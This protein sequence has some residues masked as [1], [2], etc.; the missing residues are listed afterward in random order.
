MRG[1]E[2]WRKDGWLGNRGG[3]EGMCGKEG[4]KGWEWKEGMHS[5]GMVEEG[6]NVLGMGS[7]GWRVGV[8][9]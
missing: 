3:H 9:D 5:W 8:L 4:I 6:L 1:W 2:M 7:R